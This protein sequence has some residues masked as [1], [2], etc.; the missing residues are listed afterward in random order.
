MCREFF[1]VAA[2][3][4]IVGF[5]FRLIGLVEIPE[6]CIFPRTVMAAMLALAVIYL[7]Q[8]AV[9][10]ARIRLTG[11]PPTAAPAHKTPWRPVAVALA[12]VLAYVV[13]ME[14]LGFYVSGLAFYLAISLLLQ[15]EAFTMRSAAV[16]LSMAAAFMGALY[17]LFNRILAVQVPKGILM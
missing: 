8:S 15:R 11:A 1:A 12:C 16:R 17:I 14:R 9:R 4:A 7:A 3:L 5:F 13:V 10:L 6:A 2:M